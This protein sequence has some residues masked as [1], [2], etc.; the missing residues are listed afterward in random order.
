MPSSEQRQH[1][2]VQRLRQ[3]GAVSSGIICSITRSVAWDGAA[4]RTARRMA[5][6]SLSF[7][8][9]I[10]SINRYASQEGS[11]SLKKSPAFSARRSEAILL[12]SATT[13]GRSNSA[14]RAAGATS[15][16]A[17]S[18]RPVYS[19]PAPERPNVTAETLRKRRWIR[20]HEPPPV[21]AWR[22]RM[23]SEEGQEVYRRR[24]LTER[25]HG[26]IKT[27]GMTR[28]PAHG[29][30]KVRS[31]CLLQALALNVPGRRRCAAV[32]PRRQQWRCRRPHDHSPTPQKCSPL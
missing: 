20:R 27:R 21:M 5:W 7:Q 17:R 15:R 2:N 9:W 13:C 32:L 18:R 29:R 25:A 8:S 24:K 26:I 22:V 19:P 14:P 11:A 6:V 28:S 1:M 30:E 16:M 23:A 3:W 10:T 31:V 4:R 12:A